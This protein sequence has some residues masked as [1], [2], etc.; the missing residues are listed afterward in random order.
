MGKI[1][2]GL[3]KKTRAAFEASSYK[4]NFKLLEETGIYEITGNKVIG[5]RAKGKKGINA[6]RMEVEDPIAES[7]FIFDI[8]STGGKKTN[9]PGNKGVMCILGDS[10]RLTYRE[11][12]STLN[13]PAIEIY[14][15][16][17]KTVKIHFFKKE[18]TSGKN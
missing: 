3:F 15:I 1:N 7:A 17:N 14:G 10:V 11:K 16:L 4:R 12:T 18:D 2:K 13:S 9:L 6:R 5:K 8:L